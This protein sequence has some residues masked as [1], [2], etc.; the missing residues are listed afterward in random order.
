VLLQSAEDE[1]DAVERGIAGALRCHRL[2]RPLPSFQ[3]ASTIGVRGGGCAPG[4]LC[5]GRAPVADDI[6]RAM[7]AATLHGFRISRREPPWLTTDR[8]IAMT[9][10]DN[11]T[12]DT[13]TSHGPASDGAGAD[14]VRL[15]DKGSAPTRFARGWHCLG[16]AEWFRDGTPHSVHA[17]GGKLVVWED[18]KGTL[19]VLD[20]YCRHMGGDLS[21]GT[22]KGDEVACPFHDWRWGGDGKCK[23]IPYAKRVP[24]RAR[25]QTWPTMERNG[26]LFVWND[27]EGG[28]PTETETIPEIEGYDTGKWTD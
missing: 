2:H 8:G 6:L 23:Q 26:Q 1:V 5:A 22:I 25:T 10:I 9:T 28:A 27:P 12:A 7:W 11:A 24:M 20:S 16:L 4:S 21:Q 13:T 17:F 3:A 15:I 14:E 18:S 19:N